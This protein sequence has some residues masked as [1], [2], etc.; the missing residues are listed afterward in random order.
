[1]AMHTQFQYLNHLLLF[2][3]CVSRA[4]VLNALG[5]DARSKP[6]EAL[7]RQLCGF[8]IKS[9]LFDDGAVAFFA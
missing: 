1:M 7:A 2:V 3:L 4:V 6:R 9:I 5:V 8:S